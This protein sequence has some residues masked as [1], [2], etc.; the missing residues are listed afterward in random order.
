MLKKNIF[1]AE[2]AGE[3]VGTA[4][5]KENEIASV[6]ISPDYMGRGVGRQLIHFLEEKIKANGFY[7]VKVKAS[8]TAYE[9]YKRVGYQDDEVGELTVEMHKDFR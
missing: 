2:L 8:F 4:S 9:F 3:I 1:I 7:N 5:N 6:Y